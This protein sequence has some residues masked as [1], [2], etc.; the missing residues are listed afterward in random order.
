MGRS[1][2]NVNEI[3]LD[4]ECLEELLMLKEKHPEMTN[5]EIFEI[6]DA[7]RKMVWDDGRRV[8]TVQYL[9]CAITNRV[10]A[11]DMV[12]GGWGGKV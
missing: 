4:G 10:Q 12:S 6:D 3:L 1:D 2:C 9:N 7:V 8:A 5:N 11:D